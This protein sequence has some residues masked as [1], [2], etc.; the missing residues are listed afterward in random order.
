MPSAEEIHQYLHGAWRMMLGKADGLRELDLSV[1]GFWNSFFAVAI[2]LPAL[3]VNWVTIA[4][5]YGDLAVDFNDRFAIFIRLGIIDLA[6]WLLPLAGLAAVARTVRL[7]DRYVHYVVASNWATAIVAWLMVPPAALLLILPDETDLAWFL[8]I[9]IFI[10]SQIFVWR[11]TNVAI[12]KGAT[13]ASAVYA[14]MLV[15]SIVIL[16]ALQWLL[17]LT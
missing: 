10:A 12:G 6:A 15:A 7:A 14:G 9:A 3:I 16:I 1:D 2:A 5:S 17:G 8:S 13:I 11:M 4:D